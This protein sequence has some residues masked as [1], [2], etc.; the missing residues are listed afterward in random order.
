MTTSPSSLPAEDSTFP[1]RLNPLVRN[2]RP[3]ATLAI[4][5]KSALLARQGRKVY[6][7]G[8]GQSPFP[9]PAPLV[10]ALQSNAAQKDYLPVKGLAELRGAVADYYRR[11]HDLPA[12]AEDIL[13]GP[14]SKELMFQMQFAY[15]ADLVLPS[16][17]WVSYEP[18][19]QLLGRR[20]DWLPT[21]QQDGWRLRPEVLE[22]F[23]R[24]ESQQPRLLILNYPN[25]PTGLTMRA[26]ELEGLARVAQKYRLLV[27]ADEIYSGLD[28][29]G[30]HSSI[31]QYYPE[32]T[33]ISD[34]LSKWCGAGGWRLG[35][36]YFPPGLRWLLE[37]M[38]CIA[39]ETYST[40]TAPVQYA[41]VRAF[42][43]GAEIEAYLWQ[44]RRI[45][46]ALGGLV[47]RR[48]QTLGVHVNTPEG[49]F[50]L[51]PDFTPHEAK[52]R[53]RGVTSSLALCERLLA[54]TG[55]ALL[56]GADF[57]RPATELTC[58]LA[59]VDFDGNRCLAA[60]QAVSD[61]QEL[62]E[63]FLREHCGDVL[64]ALDLIGEWLQK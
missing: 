48:L 42:Q 54:E 26:A 62:G 45:L 35:T 47:C 38:A 21:H 56:P 18:Q 25:N 37:A 19:A 58:R 6:K 14:G 27:L 53:R 40:A 41:A 63:A 3:S 36:F 1:E 10:A 13:V 55:V 39:S 30:Q 60:A 61:E 22:E 64:F 46:R 31:A 8:F 12:A 34:G 59:Y 23:C 7:L 29:A 43:M 15:A 9:V 17:S 28:H 52:L 24:R 20:V 4:N 50:Y 44:A 51:F 32:G 2:L 11:C 57:G 16:P 49:A 33:I 5:E